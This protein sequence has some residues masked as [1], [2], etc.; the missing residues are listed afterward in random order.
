MQIF[1]QNE[2]DESL[3]R[4]LLLVGDPKAEAREKIREY[5]PLFGKQTQLIADY[6]VKYLDDCVLLG[7][8]QA[9]LAH[10]ARVSTV[11]EPAQLPTGFW[12]AMLTLTGRSSHFHAVQVDMLPI[13][14]E[15]VYYDR[16][17]YNA[18]R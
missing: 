7:M 12:L 4:A 5:A 13:T 1:Y 11:Y 6:L 3:H 8:D 15:R 17:T 9:W 14:I 16:G 2:D 10:S 18:K